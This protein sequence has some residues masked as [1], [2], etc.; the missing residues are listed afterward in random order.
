MGDESQEYLR[1][2]LKYSF[3]TEEEAIAWREQYLAM[4]RI[5]P[6]PR[7]LYHCWMC[8]KQHFASIKAQKA[9]ARR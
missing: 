4:G 5:R 2:A 3:E 9:T 1:C 8:W 7:E 6:G